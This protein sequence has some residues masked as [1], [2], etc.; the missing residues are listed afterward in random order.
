MI[1]VNTANTVNITI[2]RVSAVAAT[3]I[4]SIG[5]SAKEVMCSPVIVELSVI[6]LR[7]FDSINYLTKL[8]F[9]PKL[10]H[11]HVTLFL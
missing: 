5:V 11:L 10:L 7:P 8:V 3:S 2:N 4:C 1:R 9:S 6:T